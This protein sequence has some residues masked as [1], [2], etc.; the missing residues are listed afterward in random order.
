MTRMVAGGQCRV[1]SLRFFAGLREQRGRRTRLQGFV[2]V[3]E[4]NERQSSRCH[5]RPRKSRCTIRGSAR[6]LSLAIDR[7]RRR[8]R[9]LG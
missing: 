5:Q 7:P 9:Y 6:A 4:R 1:A 2:P 3:G 8:D